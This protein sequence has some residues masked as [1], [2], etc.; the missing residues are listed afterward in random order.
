MPDPV[1]LEG[2]DIPQMLDDEGLR[3]WI[4]VQ[5]WYASKS[6]SISGIEVVENVVLH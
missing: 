3:E 6:R 1:K 2:L 4:G 5:R